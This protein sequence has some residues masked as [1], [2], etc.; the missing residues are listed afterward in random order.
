MATCGVVLSPISHG[1]DVGIGNGA[2]PEEVSHEVTF[3][4]VR[5]EGDVVLKHLPPG[6]PQNRVAATDAARQ[7]RWLDVR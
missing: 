5:M 7:T 1:L 3:I 2:L 4:P 6:L